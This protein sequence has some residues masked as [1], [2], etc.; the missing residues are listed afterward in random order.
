MVDRDGDI[1]YYCGQF[2]HHGV[3]C[4]PDCCGNHQADH[5]PDI[6]A[7]LISH[8]H[9]DHLHFKSLQGLKGTRFF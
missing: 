3:N 5:L 4:Q 8:N 2:D 7:V 1:H 6:D 9:Y